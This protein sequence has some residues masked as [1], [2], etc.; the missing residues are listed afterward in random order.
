MKPQRKVHAAENPLASLHAAGQAVW[1]D[2]LAR[3]FLREGGLRKLVQDDRLSGVTSNPTIFEKAIGEGA[4]YD[5]ALEAA[6]RAGDLDPMAL[7]EQCAIEDIRSASDDL[8]PVFDATGGADGYVSLEVSPYLALDTAA[9]I[10][11][12]RRLWSAVG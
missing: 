4:D 1:L 9:T 12:A 2:F 7:Y 11:E 5:A 8:R 10:A 6:E 3:G